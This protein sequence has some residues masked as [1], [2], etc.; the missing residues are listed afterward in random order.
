MS[1]SDVL[2]NPQHATLNK[3]GVDYAGQ[4]RFASVG[5]PG[6]MTDRQH[7]TLCDLFD[8]LSDSLRGSDKYF[9]VRLMQD[10]SRMREFALGDAIYRGEG[11]E[12]ALLLTL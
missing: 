4:C 6:G 2:C 9:S 1:A 12:R 10:G 7:Y 5:R 11:Y 3:F 8:P